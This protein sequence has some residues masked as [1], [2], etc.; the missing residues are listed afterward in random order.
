M[1]MSSITCKMN[2]PTN[3]MSKGLKKN[4]NLEISCAIMVSLVHRQFDYLMQPTNGHK[5]R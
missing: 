3:N 1:K 5:M 4:V 2:A